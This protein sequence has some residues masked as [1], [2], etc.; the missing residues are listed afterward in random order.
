MGVVGRHVEAIE[1][2]AEVSHGLKL[3][4]IGFVIIIF[5]CVFAKS[6]F[7]ITLLRIVTRPWHKV[8]LW[9]ILITMNVLMWLCGICYLAQCKPA[10]ALWNTELL[11]TAQCWPTYIFETIAMI[12]GGK[13]ISSRREELMQIFTDWS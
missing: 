13:I 2:Q 10:A 12:A 7:V 8:S 6:S 11:A 1:N 4:Y 9:F 3:V 5:G